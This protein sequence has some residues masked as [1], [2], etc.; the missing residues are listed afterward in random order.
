M[1]LDGI[2]SVREFITTPVDGVTSNQSGI[3]AAVSAASSAGARLFWPVGTYVS[4]ANIPEFHSVRHV[5]PGVVKRGSDL[6]HVDPVEGNINV[7][8]VRPSGASATADGLAYANA[9]S[10][11]RIGSIL[12]NYGPVLGGT[13]R[14]KLRAGTYLD[15]VTNRLV[16]GPA[17]DT[18]QTPGD[19]PKAKDTV[20][21]GNYVIFEGPDVGY[22]PVNNSRPTPGAL[23]D[24]RG[25]NAVAFNFRGGFRAIV[26]DIKFQDYRGGGI[27]VV[28][29]C[30]RC[31]NVHTSGCGY[32][33]SGLH[34][35]LEVKG[36]WIYGGIPSTAYTGIRSLFLTKHDIGSQSAGS[37]GQG[38]LISHCNV[39]FLA[40]E[41][42]TGHSDFVSYEDNTF[43]INATVNARVNANGSNFKR[44]TVAISSRLG[45][46]VFAPS[47]VEWNT[48]TVDANVDNMRLQTGQVL[49]PA[50]N[51]AYAQSYEQVYVDHDSTS[52]SG[53]TVETTVRT[54]TIAANR[55]TCTPGSIYK[56]KAIRVRGS[57][58][59]SGTNGTKA[60]RLRLGPSNA[61]LVGGTLTAATAGGFVIEAAI[62]LTGPASQKSWMRLTASF[63][64]LTARASSTSSTVDTGSPNPIDLTLTCELSSAE[65]S[66]AM[67]TFEVE[68][69]G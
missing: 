29:G 9:I 60:F 5:G 10:V 59:I 23:F 14:V 58:T 66:F 54:Y 11:D 32:G 8:Y 43:A 28:E 68:L 27:A 61:L 4:D 34:S 57:G 22:D 37:A 40:Q 69:S 3:V 39:G 55:L 56:G 64:D 46:V 13:W 2:L 31:E 21:N 41:G 33:I 42:S 49:L 65:D 38:P 51:E 67:E 19:S 24:G 35:F 62:Y 53:S 17:L 12:L 44:N 36:G 48:G 15:G 20:L 45:A 52:V 16:V 18:D 30:L 6:F 50:T 1:P 25:A 7:I 63:G 26:R 47:N